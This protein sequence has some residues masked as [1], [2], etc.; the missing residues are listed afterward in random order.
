MINDAFSATRR[1][2]MD[3]TVED[4]WVVLRLEGF[5]EQRMEPAVARDV[6]LGW[7]RQGRRD[8]I[9]DLLEA[10]AVRLDAGGRVS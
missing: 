7:R 5:P 8:E 3:V 10:A 2:G 1:I 6:A 9:A 4:G